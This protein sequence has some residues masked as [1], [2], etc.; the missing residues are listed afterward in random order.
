MD[1]I[2]NNYLNIVQVNKAIETKFLPKNTNMLA[3]VGLELLV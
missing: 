1:Y 2:H 3:T